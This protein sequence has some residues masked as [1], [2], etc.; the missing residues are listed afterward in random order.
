MYD[1][2]TISYLLD[3]FLRALKKKPA[4]KK[5]GNSLKDMLPL[6]KG[7]SQDFYHIMPSTKMLRPKAILAK[8]TMRKSEALFSPKLNI[9]VSY[10]P[11]N[12][13]ILPNIENFFRSRRAL[14]DDGRRTL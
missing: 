8:T 4:G 9:M 14:Q 13:L 12:S 3:L 1:F 11:N 6:S 5:L 7:K 2:V 10:S